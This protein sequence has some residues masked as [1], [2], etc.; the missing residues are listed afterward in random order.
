MILKNFPPVCAAAIDDA[1]AGS[2]GCL[3]AGESY[4]CKGVLV[5]RLCV[6]V[7]DKINVRLHAVEDFEEDVSQWL[8]DCSHRI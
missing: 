6:L 2:G 7:L 8:V 5:L 1:L 4:Y 3:P